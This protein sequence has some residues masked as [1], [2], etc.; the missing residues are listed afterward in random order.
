MLRVTFIILL[1]Y[2]ALAYWSEPKEP[3]S[4]MKEMAK[5]T[6][7]DELKRNKLPYKN[8]TIS[9]SKNK[10]IADFYVHYTDGERCIEYIVKCH[11]RSCTQLQSY[12]YD[13]HGEEC[14]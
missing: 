1:I 13:F 4:K 8:I 14:P 11:G 2:F 5:R 6:I 10:A 12:D 3:S 9:V 7:V